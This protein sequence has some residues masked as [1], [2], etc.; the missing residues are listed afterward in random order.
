MPITKQ[1]KS[2]TLDGGIVLN[3]VSL[4]KLNN[5]DQLS[6]LEVLAE[7]HSTSVD[8]MLYEGKAITSVLGLD[9]KAATATKAVPS[10]C[11][12]KMPAMRF[13]SDI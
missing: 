8:K 10:G 4:K 6:A 5:K 13:K 7:S 3:L 9:K 1:T 12:V 11:D 2:I